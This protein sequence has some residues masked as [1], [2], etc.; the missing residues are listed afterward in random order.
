VFAGAEVLG[1]P[2]RTS[3]E[4]AWGSQPF[5]QY[6]TTEAG[7]I[8]AECPAHA[9]L[10]VLDDHVVLEVVDDAYRPVP[11]GTFGAAVLVTVLSSRTLP[12][13]RYELADSVALAADA[14]PC[15]RPG[16][17]IMSIA[18]RSRE[19]LRLSGDGGVVAVHPVVLTRV[20]DTAP[21]ASWQVVQHGDR[22]RVV[23]AGPRPGFEAERLRLDL[24][25]ALA[26]LEVQAVTIDVETVEALPSGATGKADRFVVRAL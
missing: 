26:A 10:H 11:P 17:R 1:P 24:L 15:G 12:L 23:V 4:Q 16:A 19:A 8:A 20:L 18:G 21:V 25:A 7:P 13:V 2:T 6:V 22:L 3:V 9:G 5:D 14:C